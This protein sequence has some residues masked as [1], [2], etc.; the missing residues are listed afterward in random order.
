LQTLVRMISWLAPHRRKPFVSAAH[1]QFW[2]ERRKHAALLPFFT[3]LIL[4]E[5]GA[6]L[7]I[8]AINERDRVIVSGILPIA[9]AFPALLAGIIGP[10][11]GK[12][13]F[14]AQQFALPSYLAARPMTDL[15][16]VAAKFKMAAL[17]AA[18]TWGLALLVPGIW[19][20]L[21]GNYARCARAFA[22]L[23]QGGE[24]SQ[25]TLAAGAL[26]LAAPALIWKQMAQGM[27]V[28][29]AGRTWFTTAHGVATTVFL[30][31]LALPGGLAFYWMPEYR[32]L[33]WRAL[34]WFVGAALAAKALTARRGRASDAD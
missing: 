30:L 8:A 18:A 9:L 3:G 28:G 21:P 25:L 11:L 12:H 2:F 16:F 10:S 4:I 7:A 32:A 26:F 33:A 27:F 31:F 14:A 6:A 15:G 23:T 24:A 22:E 13:D 34:P 1:A 5:I 29:L 17:S 19:L 20:I